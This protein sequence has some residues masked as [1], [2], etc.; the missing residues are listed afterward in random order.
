MKLAPAVVEVASAPPSDSDYEAVC[1]SET[2]SRLPVVAHS[3]NASSAVN[4]IPSLR[5]L[6]SL[7]Y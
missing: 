7:L 3:I 5:P 6:T 2:V 1:Q 4:P